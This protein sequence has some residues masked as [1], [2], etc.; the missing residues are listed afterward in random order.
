MRA[1]GVVGTELTL[2]QAVAGEAG[3]DLLLAF[4]EQR[5]MGEA[6]QRMR[7]SLVAK[8]NLMGLAYTLYCSAALRLV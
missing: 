5:T 2:H 6:M 3:L 7:R 4:R 8:G 1:A